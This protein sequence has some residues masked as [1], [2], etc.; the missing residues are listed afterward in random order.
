MNAIEIRNLSK[1]FPGSNVWD[2]LMMQTINLGLEHPAD[3]INRVLEIVRM[4][5]AASNKY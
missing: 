3:E 4:E 2:N 1:S 5:G